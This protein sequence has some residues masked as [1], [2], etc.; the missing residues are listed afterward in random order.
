M[1]PQVELHEFIGKALDSV[2]QL[3][4][5]KFCE[6]NIA[7]YERI[8]S[9]Y[10][11]RIN[12]MP[13]TEPMLLA[14]AAFG[15]KAANCTLFSFGEAIEA[16]EDIQKAFNAGGSLIEARLA[17]RSLNAKRETWGAGGFYFDVLKKALNEEPGTGGLK[18]GRARPPI[19][20]H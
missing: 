2:P 10:G 5:L 16:F 17:Q 7:R 14:T 4:G 12:I 1:F 3:A 8:Q 20:F 6:L 19:A 11:D 18:V 15:A 13:G 9:L